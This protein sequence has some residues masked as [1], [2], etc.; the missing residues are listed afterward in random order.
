MA[1]GNKTDLGTTM[2]RILCLSIAALFLMAPPAFAEKIPAAIYTDPVADPKFPASMEV[3]HVPSGGVEIN[4]IV[5]TAS[6]PGPH[7][8][9]VFFHGLPGNEKNLD[10]AQ[11]ARRAGWNAVMVNYRGSWGSPGTYSFAGNLEDAKA[12][13][14]YIRDGDHAAK[15]KIDRTRIALG[16]HSMGGWVTVHTLAQDADV[17]GAVVISSGDFDEGDFIAGREKLIKEMDEN[18]ESLAG[19]TGA[20]MAD[21]ILAHHGVWS[22]KTLAPKLLKKR[23]YVLYSEDFVKADSVGLIKAVKDAGG[24]MIR[25]KYVVTDHSWSDRRIELE[26]LVIRWLEALPKGAQ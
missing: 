12:V 17:L 14:A 26:A 11:A 23:L 18:R 10:L 4:G 1:P 6:G 16:G 21:E 20:Q 15:L 24:K 25:E 3:I 5:Y 19:V 9:F 8:T 22:I 2:L 13:L 7:P